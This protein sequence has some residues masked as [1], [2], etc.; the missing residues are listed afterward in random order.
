MFTII[1]D[2]LHVLT[3]LH[4][5]AQ[6]LMRWILEATWLLQ[7]FQS[8]QL[9]AK[10]FYEKIKSSTAIGKT[11]NIKISLLVLSQNISNLLTLQECLSL[12]SLRLSLTIFELLCSLDTLQRDAGHIYNHKWYVCSLYM[13]ML[14][15]VGLLF[16][17]QPLVD[18]IK[19][20]GR[21]RSLVSSFFNQFF[22]AIPF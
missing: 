14:Y 6:I 19:I 15:R 8:K 10:G 17:G 3:S 2:M 9:H 11:N 21:K 13:D 7:G 12:Q 20:G 4:F 16:L 18:S 22:I 5:L 1:N